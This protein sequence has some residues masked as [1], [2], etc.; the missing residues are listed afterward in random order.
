MAVVERLSWSRNAIGIKV[1]RLRGGREIRYLEM[2]L[3]SDLLE[4]DPPPDG[5]GAADPLPGARTR[6][7][8]YVDGTGLYGTPVSEEATA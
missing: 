8:A 7:P 3:I 1:G 2:P 5:G 6:W 4:R